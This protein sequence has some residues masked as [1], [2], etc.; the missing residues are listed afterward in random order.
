MA[1][2]MRISDWSSDLCSSDLEVADPGGGLQ[3]DADGDVE[4]FEA[5]SGLGGVAGAGAVFGGCGGGI[6]VPELFDERGDGGEVVLAVP[7]AV[8][9]EGVVGAVGV[10]FGELADHRSEERRVGKEGV[11][12]CR[13]RRSPYP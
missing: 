9:A 10:A 11:S 7:G 12:T 6:G 8:L 5:G 2:E 3:V 4:G 1:Y 13:S